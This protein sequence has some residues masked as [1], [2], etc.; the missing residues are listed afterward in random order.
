MIGKFVKGVLR[1]AVAQPWEYVGEGAPN[2]WEF[3]VSPEDGGPMALYNPYLGEWVIFT[4][5][6]V[7]A[8]ATSAEM[9][10]HTADWRQFLSTEDPDD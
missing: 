3:R 6:I 9:D 4:D 2:D 5:V 1:A 10:A 7:L 8:K